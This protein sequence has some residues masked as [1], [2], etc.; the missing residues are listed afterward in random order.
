MKTKNQSAHIINMH[1]NWSS[2]C[3]SNIPTLFDGFMISYC[4]GFVNRFLQIKNVLVK[5]LQIIIRFFV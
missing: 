4:D 2:L 1:E 3:Y 5:N